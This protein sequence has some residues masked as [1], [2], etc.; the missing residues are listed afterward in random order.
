MTNNTVTLTPIKRRFRSLDSARGIYPPILIQFLASNETEQNIEA[1]D[2]K[3]AYVGLRNAVVS[4][5][6]KKRIY[7]QQEKGEVHLKRIG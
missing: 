3:K 1:T 6:L 7:V 2:L 4:M 5:G